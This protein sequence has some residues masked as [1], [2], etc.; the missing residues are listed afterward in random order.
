MMHQGHF[1]LLSALPVQISIVSPLAPTVASVTFGK[2][3]LD[4]AI[5]SAESLIE[6]LPHSPD[7]QSN[8]GLVYLT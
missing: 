5:A 7:P 3:W 4:F 1:R 8:L 6:D 2:L